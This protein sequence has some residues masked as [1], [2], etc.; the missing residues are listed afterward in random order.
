M[1][2]P[3]A[4][5][6]GWLCASPQGPFKRTKYWFHRSSNHY[7]QDNGLDDFGLP[8]KPSVALHVNLDKTAGLSRETFTAQAAW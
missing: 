3:L 2:N 4:L 7:I 1:G 5:L 8:K 6:G